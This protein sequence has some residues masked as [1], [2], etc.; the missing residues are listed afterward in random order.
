[1]KQTSARYV[2]LRRGRVNP[3]LMDPPLRCHPS[4]EKAKELQEQI[5]PKLKQAI[6]QASSF[7]FYRKTAVKCASTPVFVE[8]G[9]W[10]SFFTCICK[11]ESC[12][13][14]KLLGHM[15]HIF[16]SGCVPHSCK[17]GDKAKTSI[18]GAASWGAKTA[19]W[20]GS[21]GLRVQ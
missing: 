5:N 3:P 18:L 16:A 11:S 4:Q 12:L 2:Q 15:L 13:R 17:A 8:S 21:Q 6:S 7:F 10:T 14:D 19:I 9:I 1:M 20:P